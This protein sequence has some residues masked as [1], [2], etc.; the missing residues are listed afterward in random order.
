MTLFSRQ[1]LSF[2]F[3]ADDKNSFA[4]LLNS[5]YGYNQLNMVEV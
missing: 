3:K 1:I 2:L 5:I 4:H